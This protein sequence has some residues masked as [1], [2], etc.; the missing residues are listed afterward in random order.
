MKISFHLPAGLALL[1]GCADARPPSAGANTTTDSLPAIVS[2]PASDTQM[3]DTATP[4]P[5]PDTLLA[6]TAKKPSVKKTN[7]VAADS[8]SVRPDSLLNYARSLRGIPY[9]YASTD[10]KKGFDC[11][12]FITH[13]FNHFGRVVP[14][15]SAGF[16][17]YG[18]AIS[19]RD[20]QPGDLL[21]FTG[22]DST[23]RVVGHMGIV[24]SRHNDTLRFIHSSSGKANG[25]VISVLG[26]YYMSRFVK[27]VRV[28]PDVLFKQ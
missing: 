18:K 12:G 22:T 20:A 6:D 16:T 10:P 11:S 2:N 24:E 27:A 13:V 8:L 21:L 26:K 5:A 17:N 14:R 7:P 1:L 23:I 4:L 25:V 3:A 9:L 28:F 19:L 15:A